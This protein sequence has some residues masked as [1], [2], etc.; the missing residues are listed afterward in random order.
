MQSLRPI[1]AVV[2]GR[3][4]SSRLPGKTMAD[5]AGHPSLWHI[6]ERLKRAA[7]LDGII[8][9]TTVDPRDDVIRACA[10]AAGVPCFSGS[11]EDVLDRTLR[12]A[13]SVGAASIVT[14]TGDCPLTDPVVV[15]KVVAAYLEERPD[16]ASNRLFGY[17]YPIGLD[18]EVFTTESLD[19]VARVALAPRDR[20]HVT[21]Y[22]YE[23]PDEFQLLGIEPED[24]QRRPTLRLTLDTA[25]DYELIRAVYDHFWPRWFGLDDVLDFVDDRPEL[26]SVN[27]DVKQVVP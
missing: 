7:L 10:E 6:V 24:R 9:A 17:K 23:H 2:P 11:A 20:E 12:A 18:V 22:Y 13:H 16:Y 5:L 21:L 26:V 8:V 1:W 27:V 25:A 3:M 14:V 4:G 15:D 19:R